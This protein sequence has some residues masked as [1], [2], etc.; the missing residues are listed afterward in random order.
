V[1]E[2]DPSTF[3]LCLTILF[4]SVLSDGI[5]N[6]SSSNQIYPTRPNIS[7]PNRIQIPVSTT[8]LK[9]HDS[10]SPT[11]NPKA[12]HIPRQFIFESCVGNYCRAKSNQTLGRVNRPISRNLFALFF[13]ETNSAGAFV[14]REIISDPIIRV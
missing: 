5:L 9:S 8:I 11:K 14:F 2:S 7:C 1:S 12:G 4:E 6:M 10:P 3:G 13:V